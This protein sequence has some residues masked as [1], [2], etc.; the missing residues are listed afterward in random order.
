[1][2]HS[3]YEE[4]LR[5]LQQ[6]EN[7]NDDDYGQAPASNFY[8]NAPLLQSSPMSGQAKPSQRP[9]IIEEEESVRSEPQASKVQERA[10]KPD[11][12]MMMSSSDLARRAFDGSQ[13]RKN[14]S[15]IR[16]DGFLSYFNPLNW[17]KWGKERRLA[18]Q[19][20]GAIA[21]PSSAPGFSMT[22]A[23][24]AALNTTHGQKILRGAAKKNIK[25]EQDVRSSLNFRREES[26]RAEAHVARHAPERKYQVHRN[27]EALERIPKSQ[28]TRA[29]HL[30]YTLDSG[31][32]V[33]SAKAM[34][35]FEP[36]NYAQWKRDEARDEE[37]AMANSNRADKKLAKSSW[38]RSHARAFRDAREKT[39]EE[40]L[41][42]ARENH[43]ANRAM[44]PLLRKNQDLPPV[45]LEM[46]GKTSPEAGKSRQWADAVRPNLPGL[47]NKAILPWENAFKRNS[48]AFEFE[49]NVEDAE[50]SA[51]E[52]GALEG[53][54]HTQ[55]DA[56]VM[57]K[58]KQDSIDIDDDDAQQEQQNMFGLHYGQASLMNKKATKRAHDSSDDEDLDSDKHKSGQDVFRNF[59]YS[60]LMK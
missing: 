49:G 32:L 15:S 2:S 11:D 16:K 33:D 14:P 13:A 52:S 18:R 10:S 44:Q 46:W 12:P 19:A 40:D 48:G 57:G 41:A 3:S 34:Q 37:A 50:D 54:S 20:A 60:Q 42:A 27:D 25:A 53:I 7:D 28:W 39:T 47:R 35:T 21:D 58:V 55:P 36:Q 8:R 31:P 45:M 23:H 5:L 4:D 51:P 24:T 22:P 29:D 38:G 30:G 9:L 1:M 59:I 6:D 56:K 26:G 17:F 43:R